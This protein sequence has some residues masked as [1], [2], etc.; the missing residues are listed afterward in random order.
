M[1]RETVL[2]L[3]VTGRVQGVSFRAWTQAEALQRGLDGWVRNEADGSVSGVIAG[4]AAAVAA[5]LR[6]LQRGPG[7][8]RVTGVTTAPYDGDVAGGFVIRR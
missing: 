3:R 2:S 4:D 6:A 8:A 5:M 1:A 7:A